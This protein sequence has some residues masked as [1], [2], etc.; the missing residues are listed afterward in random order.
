MWAY[1]AQLTHQET[2]LCEDSYPETIPTGGSCPACLGTEAPSH[3]RGHPRAE[4]TLHMYP[5]YFSQ[6]PYVDKLI[7]KT[8]FLGQFQYMAE[9]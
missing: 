6:P 5:V 1:P 8:I 3:F 2:Q 9:K 7:R 4:H